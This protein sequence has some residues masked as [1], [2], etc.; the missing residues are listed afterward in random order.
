MW[1]DFKQWLLKWRSVTVASMGAAGCVLL[2]RT[3]GLLQTAEWA[4]ADIFLRLRPAEPHDDRLLVVGIDEEDLQRLGRWPVPDGVLAEAIETL[5]RYDPRAVGLDLYRDLPVEPGHDRIVELFETSSNL[6]GIEKLED[7]RMSGVA[8]PPALSL[9]DAVG[10]NNTI[11]DSDGI[12]RRGYLFLQDDTGTLHRSFALRLVQLYLEVENIRPEAGP[13]GYM[14]LGRAIVPKFQEADGG[15]TRADDR[16]YQFLA[17]YRGPVTK[18]PTVHLRDVLEDAVPPEMI[19]D[20]IVVIGSTASSI[21]DMFVT[22]YSRQVLKPQDEVPGVLLQAEF[23]GQILDASLEGRPLL[24]VWPELLEIAWIVGW[25]WFGALVSWRLHSVKGATVAVAIAAVALT[26]VCYVA[27]LGSWWIP[28]IPSMLSLLGST[29]AIVGYL[30]YLG[31]ELRK[32]KE[33]LQSI[34]NTIPDPIFVKD[35]AH[36]WIVLNEAYGKLVG[37]SLENLIDRSEFEVF[38]ADQAQT[39]R[40]EDDVVLKTGRDRESEDQFT[41]ARGNVRIIAT[42]RS[43]HRD[44]A[45]NLFLVGVIRDITERKHMEEQLKQIAAELAQSNQ[46]LQQDASHDELTGLPNHKQFYERLKQSL[47]WAQSRQKCVGVMFLDLDGFKEV[48]D[49]LGH[50]TGNALLKAVAQRLSDSLRGSDTVARWGGDEFTVIL[51]G[52]PSTDD[53]IRVAEKLI[54]GLAEPFALEAGTVSV[55]ASIGIGLYP[56]HSE[57]IDELIRLA[58]E[59]ML[60]AKKQGKS[61]YVLVEEIHLEEE[62]SFSVTSHQSPVTSEDS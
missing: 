53:A 56:T 42:K 5:Y 4:T 11:V 43:L 39:F 3:I 44:G 20:R 12:V 19:R 25:A 7:Q 59:A 40:D 30:A 14:K 62:Q 45:G 21:R 1:S 10:F 48:N 22:P 29:V 9:R 38:P 50:L 47:E 58:D 54:R 15:Y 49:T 57:D 26:G 37:Y 35:T 41:D 61:R 32:S 8:P 28:I 31:E 34:I 60:Q 17:N 6:V 46:E 27:Y 16:G 23:V 52:I 55:T 13:H 2:L 36:R 51:P 24:R 18:I 33:F